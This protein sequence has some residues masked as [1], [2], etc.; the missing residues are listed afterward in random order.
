MVL[1]FAELCATLFRVATIPIEVLQSL[2]KTDLH[3]HLDGSLR[4]TTVLALAEQ[5]GVSLAADTPEGLAKAMRCGEHTGSL[6]EYLKAFDVTLSVLQ[7][8]PALYRAAYEL[9]EDA[10]AENVHYMEVRY[11]PLLHQQAGLRQAAVIEAVLAGLRQAGKDFAVE[12]NAIICGMRNISPESSL[13]MARLAVAYKNRGVVAF[14]LAG[15]EY[16]HP[17]KHHRAAFQLI[18][19][20]NINCTIHAGEAFGPESISQA[21][22][23]CGAHRLGHG[24]RLR[25][26]GELLHYV[27]DHRIALEACP[28]SNVQT[29]AVESLEN[30]P[31]KLYHDLGL[32]VTVNTDNR[33]ITDTTVSRELHLCHV[34]M[35]LGPTDITRLILNGFK[36]A[37]LPFHEKQV[38]L[39]RVSKALEGFVAQ[40]EAPLHGAEAGAEGAKAGRSASLQLSSL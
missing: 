32:R 28:S 5:A 1:A 30:H 10:A 2:P 15:A 22:H 12:A 21:L 25:E 40:P 33:L 34:R 18:R 14:D 38:Y 16:D 29:G 6:V 17:A 26:D 11:A 7:S 4:L 35:G 23:V 13:E 3:V 36:A 20:N 9:V 39:R 19:N 37:F 31:L 27:N 8:E 24:C